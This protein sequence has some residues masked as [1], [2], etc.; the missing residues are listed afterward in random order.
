LGSLRVDD[1]EVAE[2]ALLD[3][4]QRGD[5]SAVAD[6]L[7]DDFVITTAG[8]LPEPVGKAAWLEGLSGHMTLERYDLRVIATRRY[9]DVGVVLAE[10]GQKG[11]HDGVLYSMSFRYTDVW[12]LEGEGWRLAIRHASGRPVQQAIPEA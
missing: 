4:L 2:R 5:L 10:T 1:L 9:G 3:A 12:V 7:R 6:L 11:T 8:W